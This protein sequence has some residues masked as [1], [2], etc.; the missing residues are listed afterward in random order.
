MTSFEIE[1]PSGINSKLISLGFNFFNSQRNGSTSSEEEIQIS[2]I[3]F[4]FS[5]FVNLVK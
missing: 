3:A 1:T 2:G 5:T 4:H